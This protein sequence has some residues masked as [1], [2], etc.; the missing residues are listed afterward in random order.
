MR[1]LPSIVY[2]SII[3]TRWLWGR[4][5]MHAWHLHTIAM[6]VFL[7]YKHCPYRQHRKIHPSPE[8]YQRCHTGR[9]AAW[10][11]GYWL[12]ATCDLPSTTPAR[13]APSYWGGSQYSCGVSWG[14]SSSPP[15]FSST[16][17]AWYCMRCLRGASASQRRYIDIQSMLS[18]RCARRC[19]G[20]VPSSSYSARS[21]SS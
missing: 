3:P 7:L 17:S 11:A 2:I 4:P 5:T 1:L 8:K 14:L 13:T 21:V 6:L 12:W 9:K 16:L 18:M 20:V 19:S 15:S 10:R